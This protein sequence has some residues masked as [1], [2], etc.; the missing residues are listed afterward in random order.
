VAAAHGLEA[1]FAAEARRRRAI[2]TVAAAAGALAAL[3]LILWVTV[4]VP[5]GTPR[6][7]PGYGVSLALLLAAGAVLAGVV[8]VPGRWR[9][10]A[11]AAV[12]VLA[13]LDVAAFE[14]GFR[15]TEA[16]PDDQ[17]DRRFLAGL[18]DLTHDW[19][20]LDEFVMEQRP[21]SRLRIRD[22]RG[23]PSGDPFEEQRYFDV[24]HRATRSPQILEAFNVRY[25]FHG[26]HHRN[27][28]SRNY[29]PQPPSRMAPAHF[30][31]LDRVRFEALHPA[32]QVAWYG[33]V[34]EVHSPAE[35]LAAVE[36]L[37]EADG[38]RRRVVI[39]AGDV[40]A[41]A[42]P[43][44]EAL[45]PASAAPPASTSGAVTGYQNARVAFTID[46]PAAGIAV[47]NEKAAPG[48]RVS[49][50]GR[51]APALR[52]N[53][54]L[55]GVLLAPGRHEVVWTYAPR[56][57][58]T[59]AALWVAGVLFLLAALAWPRLRRRTA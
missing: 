24:L 57:Y 44:L 52:V 13:Y 30:R 40:P 59:L 29:V 19:R 10:L 14:D 37:E 56:R 2:V 25:V 22:F 54:M 33:A 6:D 28:K 42:R 17:E 20:V 11:G 5:A 47:L 4:G 3:L 36:A 26:A 16:P 53:Y 23:Y 7:R 46:A 21:G 8:W 58:R 12:V 9:P 41:E 27:G 55:R 50:D 34:T 15:A 32:P 45:A 43:G 31:Q 39:E 35:A 38:S 48:W 1:L 51:V 18:A 49:V